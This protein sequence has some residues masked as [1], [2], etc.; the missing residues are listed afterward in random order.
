MRKLSP[1]QDMPVTSCN[2]EYI[3]NLGFVGRDLGK[4]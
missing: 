2:V 4:L 1:A 3:V